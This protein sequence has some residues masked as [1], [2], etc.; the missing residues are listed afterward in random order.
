MLEF[1]LGLVRLKYLCKYNY[2]VIIQLLYNNLEEKMIKWII[3]G[4]VVLVIIVYLISL[5]NSLVRKRNSVEEAFSTMDV[6]FKK[7]WDAIPNL[8]ETVKGYAKHEAGLLENIVKLRTGVTY[9]SMTTNEKIEANKQLSAGLGKLFAVAE[10]YPDLKS[11]TNFQDL[12]DKIIRVEDEIAN[13]R[14]YY[15]GTVREFNNKIQ[16]F[17]NVIFAGMFGFKK[18]NMYEID[19]AE[20]ENVKVEF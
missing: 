17:P 9:D 14:K 6:Y 7:R 15:N 12:S 18:F 19:T 10:S 8:V 16:V 2:I 13:A 4:A 11:N 3:L 1:F 5:Y 20:R